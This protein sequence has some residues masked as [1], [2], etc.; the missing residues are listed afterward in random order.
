MNLFKRGIATMFFILILGNIL[1][2]EG[3]EINTVSKE[4]VAL[5][6]FEALKERFEKGVDEKDLLSI[7]DLSLIHI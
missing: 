3:L 7:V 1:G 4:V 5:N 6:Y 2:G